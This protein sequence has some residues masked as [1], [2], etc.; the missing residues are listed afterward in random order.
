MAFLWYQFINLNW[1][2]KESNLTVAKTATPLGQFNRDMKIPEGERLW[3]VG[4]NGSN[5]Q[6][7]DRFCNFKNLCFSNAYK[8]FFLNRGD[9]FTYKGDNWTSHN[10]AVRHTNHIS[11]T[12]VRGANIVFDYVDYPAKDVEIPEHE[13]RY[14]QRG[15]YFMTSRISGYNIA[16]DIHDVLMPLFFSMNLSQQSELSHSLILNFRNEMIGD[17]EELYNIFSAKQPIL[18]LDFEHFMPSQSVVCFEDVTTGLVSNISL[19]YQWGM[20]EKH[21][22]PLPNPKVTPE[23]FREFKD[24]VIQKL[25]IRDV[26]ECPSMMPYGVLFSRKR[27]RKILNQKALIGS[28]ENEFQLTMQVVSL[29]EDSVKEIIRQLSCARLLVSMHGALMILSMFLPRGAMVVEM[30]PYAINPDFYQVY[31]RMLELQDLDIEYIAWRNMNVSESVIPSGYYFLINEL[32]VEERSAILSRTE[33]PRKICCTDPEWEF[34]IYQDTRV[35]VTEVIDLL[36][37]KL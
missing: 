14:Y 22:G 2:T 30:Y 7:T 9:N 35:N 28:I 19:W 1:T 26:T 34:R 21:E 10:Q 16:H 3:C 15:K 24:Y 37:D 25:G 32:D 12:T 4:P 27:H 8:V 23:H 33:A 31:K 36:K 29:E 17:S 11:L 5:S 20:A 18:Q 13:Y 6:N